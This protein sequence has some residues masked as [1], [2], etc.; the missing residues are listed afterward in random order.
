MRPDFWTKSEFKRF[1]VDYI[2]GGL[3]CAE[4]TLERAMA[5]RRLFIL[6]VILYQSQGFVHR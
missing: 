4:G 2:E 6:N 1:F 3:S 5:E